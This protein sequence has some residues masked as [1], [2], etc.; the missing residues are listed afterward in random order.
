MVA[1]FN[2]YQELVDRA[3]MIEG[4]QQQIENRKRKYGQGKY[5]SGAQQ[6]PR[7][8]PKPGVPFQHTHGGSGSH[9]HNGHKNGN[10]NGGSNGQNRTI[11]SAPAKKDLSHITCYK[12]SKTGHYANECP[13]G[14]NGN[15]RS[16]KKP[17]PFNRGQVNHV[18]VEEVEAQPDAV[19]GKFLVKSFTAL[20]LFD[21]GA[22]HSYISRGFVEK[23]SLPT[24]G[25]KTPM[26]VSSPGAEYMASQGCFQVPL[27]I[28]RHVFPTDLIILESQGLDVILDM[29]WLSM[30][31]GNIDCASKTILL[32]TLEGRRIKYVSRHASNRTQVNSLSGVVQ[33]EVPVVKDFPDVFP[34]ELPGMPPDRDI[35]FF[36]ELLPGTGPISKRP[37]RMPAKDLVEIKKQIK[38]LLD[39]GYIRPSSS[40]WGSPVLLVE[41][42]DGSLR[43]VVDYRGL[44]EVT[45][46]NKYP[47]PMINDLFDRLQGA[48]VFSKIDLRSGYHQLKIREQ[49]IPKTAFTTRYGLYEY[50]VMSFGLT[51]APAYFMNLMN[52]VFMEFLDK[53][54]VVFIDDI[55]VFSKD[56]EEHEAHLR[57]VLEK[58]RE[59]KLYA[60]FSKCEFWLEEVGFLG[61]VMTKDGVAVDPAKVSAMTEWESPKSV[62][63]VRSFL[64]LA[65]YYRR[66]IENFSKVAKPMT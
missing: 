38:E 10:G 17:N 61:H 42:K 39:K 7:F 24:R 37:Y 48:K 32:T 27:S 19:I 49:D 4:K 25:L 58:L 60:K 9:N 1:S 30:Y 43:M 14:Q 8:T 59:H 65:G 13:E 62:K 63:E 31:G 55:L 36:I 34:E 5:N 29:D 41:K 45:I 64:G 21:T 46:K 33:E 53:F 56:E 47:L 3:I 35:E 22:S 15:G 44:N 2:N 11:P 23:Y 40:P 66:F 51:N 6:K 16:G 26:L 20:V 28:G 54:V 12:C 57:L 18:N 52:K 50:T